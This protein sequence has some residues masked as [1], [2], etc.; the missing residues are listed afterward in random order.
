M[1]FVVIIIIFF[2]QSMILSLGDD[3]YT[4][5]RAPD[6][7]VITSGKTLQLPSSDIQPCLMSRGSC[8]LLPAKSGGLSR[9]MPSAQLSF[10][11]SNCPSSAAKCLLL[12]E[13]SQKRKASPKLHHSV[14][15]E[16]DEHHVDD[17]NDGTHLAIKTD[18]IKFANSLG[19]M[20]KE[21]AEKMPLNTQLQFVQKM[22]AIVGDI[23]HAIA[24]G[25]YLTQES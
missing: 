18:V 13:I 14:K 15:A 1:Y 25:E 7:A 5:E 3:G 17:V 10:G 4:T 23:N 11:P 2:F 6:P 22:L 24:A 19:K 16:R 21:A 8:S 12:E 20:V 9:P